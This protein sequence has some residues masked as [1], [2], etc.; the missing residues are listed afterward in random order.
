MATTSMSLPKFC[1]AARSTL[2][3]MRPK[4]LMPTLIAMSLDSRK[5]NGGKVAAGATESGYFNPSESPPPPPET[6]MR[7]AAA[8]LFTLAALSAAAPA[9]AWSVL[10]H[11]LVGELAQRH[12]DPAVNAE[13]ERLLAGEPGP[14]LAGVAAWADRLRDLDPDRFKATSTWHYVNTPP[15][16]HCEYVAGRD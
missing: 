16:K 15:G 3:P 13:V 4:P 14:T 11:Q 1:T 12:R 10:G 9:L 6:A 5:R 7:R 8:V 2:R